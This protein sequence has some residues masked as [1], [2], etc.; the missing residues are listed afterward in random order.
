MKLSG[1]W[2]RF[3]VTNKAKA[4]ALNGLIAYAVISSTEND[5]G[6]LIWPEGVGEEDDSTVTITPTAAATAAASTRSVGGEDAVGD[7]FVDAANGD[8]SNT[9]TSAS[10]FATIA[11]GAAAVAKAQTQTQTH[12]GNGGSGGSGGSG[13]NHTLHIRGGRYFLKE[14]IKLTS[15]HSGS[16]ASSPVLF[17]A[18]PGTGRVRVIGGVELNS[19]TTTS[20]TAFTVSTTSTASTAST[21][22]S[23]VSSS[24]S[25]SSSGSI[26]VI[27]L[28]AAGV[29]GV[30]GG[31]V[32][33]GGYNNDCTGS[34]VRRERERGKE[35]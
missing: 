9:G 4:G 14:P 8:D 3:T 5:V 32:A 16:S 25:S 28:N 19:T 23:T 20:T 26:Q 22:S 35:E 21:T 11:A 29:G 33:Q 31:L 13:G 18:V 27:D 7:W 6:P 10:P 24:S 30:M 17:I 12:G 34:Q 15:A 2:H 1:R